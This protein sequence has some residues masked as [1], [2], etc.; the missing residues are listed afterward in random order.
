MA[1]RTLPWTQDPDDGVWALFGAEWRDVFVTDPDGVVTEVKNL[2][3]YDLTDSANA[4]AF[5]DALRDAA[6]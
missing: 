2:T 3:S 1:G 5:A 6:P 4:D